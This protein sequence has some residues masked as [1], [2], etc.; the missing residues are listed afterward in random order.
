MAND[1]KLFVCYIP[2]LDRRRVDAQRTPYVH[3]LLNDYP[4]C[5]LQTIPSTELTPTLLTGVGPHKNLIWQVSLKDDVPLSPMD[6]MIDLLPEVVT[7]TA[8]CF[9]HL[10][11]SK[12]D[13]AA[14]PR[15]R[16]RQFNLHR[17]K[18]TRRETDPNCLDQIGGYS[19][20]LKELGH[21]DAGYVFCKH[22]SD[23]E[24]GLSVF[25][26]EGKRLDFVEFYGFDLYS[27]WHLDQPDK[28]DEKLRFVDS[29]IQRLHK[30]CSDAGVTMMLLVDHGQEQIKSSVNIIKRLKRSGVPRDEY[31]Y[32][33]EVSAVRFWFK[34][35]R[36]RTEIT[37]LLEGDQDVTV[38]TRQEM[39][40]YGICFDDPSF[41]ELYCFANHGHTFFPHDFYN[42]IANLFL[43]LTD[44][45]LRPRLL[46]ARHRG[47][48]G[49]LPTHPAEE[50]YLVLGGEG[51]EATTSQADIV[52]FAPTV[53][54]LLGCEPAEH[55]TGQTVF[56]RTGQA[57]TAPTPAS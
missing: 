3:S 55:M 14:V 20:I 1:M 40:E 26:R 6:K 16:R 7:T 57:E 41:G 48:H 47:N 53:L 24:H 5:T 36:A 8:Q 51:F 15:H 34:T 23:M 30:R 39:H 29:F 44:R 18:Y 45:L 17:M 9:G 28:I 37:R 32:F 2:G 27:H 50:G 56:V 10:L 12:R 52:D 4:S 42:P 11:N 33:V 21:D 43:G 25:P 19:S 31:V 54:N 22:F 13:L 38:K 35:E 49:H 46:N